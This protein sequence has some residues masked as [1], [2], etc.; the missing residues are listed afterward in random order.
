MVRTLSSLIIT[1]SCVTKKLLYAPF[2]YE[3]VLAGLQFVS[4]D[5]RREC[6]QTSYSFK[7]VL[8]LSV[9]WFSFSISLHYTQYYFGGLKFS[10]Q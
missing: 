10:Y 3:Y 8:Y 1:S 7:M 9:P 2:L 6:L 5:G 4:T